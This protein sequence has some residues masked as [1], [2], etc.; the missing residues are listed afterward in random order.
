MSAKEGKKNVFDVAKPGSTAP[1]STSKPVI[2]SHKPII[3]DS[4][5]LAEKKASDNT[6]GE[7]TKTSI[8]KVTT[9]KV[10]QPLTPQESDEEEAKSESTNK[11]EDTPEDE[12]KV[13]KEMPDDSGELDDKLREE[14]IVDAVVSQSDSK[15]VKKKEADEQ[16]LRTEKID[17][18]IA[19][20][21]YYVKIKQTRSKRNKK[22]L[23]LILFI[24]FLGM[25]AFGLAADAEIIDFNVPF[26][27][28]KQSKP[29]P[30]QPSI[31]NK[32]NTTDSTKIQEVL[33]E[34][35]VA[36]VNYQV[37]SDKN[38]GFS[39]EYPD[40]LNPKVYLDTMYTKNGKL[41]V[42]SLGEKISGYANSADWSV[43]DD[44]SKNFLY[45]AEY[46]ECASEFNST[47]V[48]VTFYSSDDSCVKAYNY[49]YD[50]VDATD[51]PAARLVAQ[52]KVNTNTGIN[53]F[54]VG[55][56]PSGNPNNDEVSEE[57]MKARYNDAALEFQKIINSVKPL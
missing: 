23:L 54:Y 14:A 11:T 47:T 17:K 36:P 1:S 55:T 10:I 46:N 16:L 30:T 20:K 42:V 5:V 18:L 7:A 25:I 22:K 48:V 13:S 53:L 45:S 19:S 2:I 33:K 32:V 43:A 44:Q 12:E 24:V 8:E 31:V 4:T 28:I 40:T 49:R 38:L 37:Y 41:Y 39:F 27:F 50:D 3:K 52:K 51:K 35:E 15:I 6:E 9:A 21:Q 34:E 29:T 57:V 26:D 56:S